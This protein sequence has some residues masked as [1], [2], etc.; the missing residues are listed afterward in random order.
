MVK[1]SE[2]HKVSTCPYKLRMGALACAHPHMGKTEKTVSS[3]THY[4]LSLAS[5]KVSHLYQFGSI[6]TPAP[7]AS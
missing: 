2:F 5:G 7:A 3:G 4:F 1:R 6:L